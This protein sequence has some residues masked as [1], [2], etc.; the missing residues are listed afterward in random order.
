MFVFAQWRLSSSVVLL[1][2]R[3][4]RLTTQIARPS[5]GGYNDIDNR[6][7]MACTGKPEVDAHAS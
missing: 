1:S 4:R 6:E 5:F 7:K 3:L 2:A